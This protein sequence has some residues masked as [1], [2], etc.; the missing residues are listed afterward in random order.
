M[1]E[2]KFGRSETRSLRPR[3]AERLAAAL[4]FP[5]MA[6]YFLKVTETSN[7]SFFMPSVV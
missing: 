3:S 7:E 1:T 5:P 2:L 6:R 4:R